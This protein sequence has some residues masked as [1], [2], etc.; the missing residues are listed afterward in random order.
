M[1][2]NEDKLR[3]VST[4]MTNQKFITESMRGVLIDW[5]VDVSIHF[6][7]MTDTLHFAIAYVDRTLSKAQIEKSKLQLV[8][9]TCMKL[10]DVFNEKS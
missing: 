9:V 4:Y 8:G 6:E 2:K 3:P 1:K 10:A 5:L 7:L